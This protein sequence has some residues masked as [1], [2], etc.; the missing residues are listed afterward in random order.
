MIADYFGV[1][2]AIIARLK[3]EVPEVPESHIFTPFGLDGMMENSQPSPSLHVIYA[4]DAVTGDEVGARTRQIVGQRW[5]VVLAVRNAKAQLKN[6]TEIRTAAGVIIPK[7][8]NALQGWAPAEW[9][10]PL[11]RVSGPAAG[12][13]SAFAYFPFM[14][15]GRIIT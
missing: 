4:G 7:L 3:A 9:M 11:G 5:L 2:P 12:Y 8:L 13:S 1:E 6:T 14:F 15:E 10:R